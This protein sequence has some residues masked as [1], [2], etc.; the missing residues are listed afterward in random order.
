MRR[1][2]AVSTTF[3]ICPESKTNNA[4]DGLVQYLL[5]FYKKND[6]MILTK[7]D[8]LCH[9]PFDIYLIQVAIIEELIK[10]AK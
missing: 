4:Q 5:I 2:A 9:Q 10:N 8:I 6:H 1:T 7:C 3:R